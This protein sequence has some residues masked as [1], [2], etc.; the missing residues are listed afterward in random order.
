MFI[1]GKK[2]DDSGNIINIE[3]A[4]DNIFTSS[5]TKNVHSHTNNNDDKV[6]ETHYSKEDHKDNIVENRNNIDTSDTSN[7]KPYPGEKFSDYMV[8]MDQMKSE[9]SLS[10]EFNRRLM[11]E[12]FVPL[13]VHF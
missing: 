1:I 9:K 11:N 3:T 13:N 6:E 10:P 7:N 2:I 8:R 12:R 5:A 4:P